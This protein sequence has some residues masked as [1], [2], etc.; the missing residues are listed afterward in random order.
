[1]NTMIAQEVALAEDEATDKRDTAQFGMW[2]FLLSETMFF[3]GFIAA[4]VVLRI[5][6][7]EWPPPG[8]VELPW[9]L[10]LLNTGILLSSSA[11]V[12]WGHTRHDAG[13][14]G[15][16]GLALGLAAA[17]GMVFLAIQ[18]YE[19]V[20][21]VAEGLVYQSGVYGGTFY[22]LTG[23]HGLHVLLGVALLSVAALLALRGRLGP[24]RALLSNTALY[25]HFVDGVWVLLFTM[26]YLV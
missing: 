9:L 23:F 7:P 19:W 10:A 6:T 16:S 5:G 22:L 26:L 18:A 21:L 14:H 13:E 4:Y 20:H 12:H 17:M 2:V 8:Q 3:A 11:V 15:R 24:E 25:W 1:M